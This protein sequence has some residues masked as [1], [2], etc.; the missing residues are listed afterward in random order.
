LLSDWLGNQ[1]IVEVPVKLGCECEVKVDINCRVFSFSILSELR[2]ET[3]AKDKPVLSEAIFTS[4]RN[5][6]V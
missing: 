6:A 3:V 1:K 4:D 2:R 5:M